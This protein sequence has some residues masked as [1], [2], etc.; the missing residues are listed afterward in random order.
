[1]DAINISETLYGSHIPEDEGAIFWD[2]K[3]YSLLKV[4]RRFDFPP[5]FT[6]VLCPAY[7]ILKME[8]I[9]SSERSVDFQRTPR[10]YI[11]EGSTAHNYR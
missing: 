11:R 6:L 1:M 3:P 5:A 7:S 4:S 10:R 2:I 8:A 9:Y